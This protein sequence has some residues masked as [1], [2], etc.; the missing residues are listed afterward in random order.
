MQAVLLCRHDW[1]RSV[2][3]ASQRLSQDRHGPPALAERAERLLDAQCEDGL[4]VNDTPVAWRG[5][6]VD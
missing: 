5:T 6:E 2:A 1:A 3:E 4:V